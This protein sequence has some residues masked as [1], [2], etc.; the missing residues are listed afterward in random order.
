MSRY[1]V[2]LILCSWSGVHGVFLCGSPLLA[3]APVPPPVS[4]LARVRTSLL[5]YVSGVLI[6]LLKIVKVV[7]FSSLVMEATSLT[8]N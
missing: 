1:S 7:P 2:I 3:V 5:G 4:R 8:D 6:L